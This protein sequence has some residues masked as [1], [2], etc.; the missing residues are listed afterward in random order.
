MLQ[1]MYFEDLSPY[2]YCRSDF[3]REDALNVGWLETGRPYAKG[4]VPKKAISVLKKLVRRPV[5]DELWGFHA[6]DLC[7]TKPAVL[8]R[9]WPKRRHLGTGEIRVAGVNGII[10]ASPV[11]IVHY[12]KAH[13]Y[14]P[15]QEYIDALLA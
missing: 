12:I 3:E 15:P 10:Y 1:A 6:C 5:K 11:L 7:Q 8:T 4:S 2:T 9:L 13:Q 14:C